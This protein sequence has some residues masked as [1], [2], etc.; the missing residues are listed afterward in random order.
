MSHEMTY[1]QLVQKLQDWEEDDDLE[2]QASIDDIITLGELRCLKDLRLSIFEIDGTTASAIGNVHI[3][4][5]TVTESVITWLSIYYD[6]GSVRTYMQLRSNDWIRDHQ[7]PGSTAS[8]LYYSEHDETQWLVSPIPDAVLTIECRGTARPEGLSG[9]NT[10]SW[11]GNNVPDLLFKACMA[12]SESF[13]KSDDRT[14]A[15][16]KQYMDLLALVRDETYEMAQR[17][18]NSTALEPP[19]TPVNPSNQR[20]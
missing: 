6:V 17:H 9:T 13:L 2:F 11:L 8:P 10:T 15:W 7:T 4:K 12:E 19:A 3:T 20:Q 1:A 14:E 16:N 5:P 18:Y